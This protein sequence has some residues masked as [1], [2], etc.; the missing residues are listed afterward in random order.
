MNLAMTVSSSLLFLAGYPVFA[1]LVLRIIH[2]TT[3]FAIYSKHNA[4]RNKQFFNN[5]AL[6]PLLKSATPAWV[7]TVLVGVFLAAPA[8]LWDLIYINM[9]ITYWHYA[10]ESFAWKRPSLLRTNMGSFVP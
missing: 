10:M 1:L 9:F 7:A 5:F 2:D 6:R 8:T 4:T 3:A